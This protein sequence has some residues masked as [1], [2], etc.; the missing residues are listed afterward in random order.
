MVAKLAEVANYCVSQAGPGISVMAAVREFIAK[1]SSH[2]ATMSDPYYV[3]YTAPKN[4]DVVMTDL[5]KR[6]PAVSG[7]P[8]VLPSL[9]CYDATDIMI[10][11][12]GAL[13]IEAR[14]VRVISLQPLTFA[15]SYPVYLDHTMAEVWSGGK[16]S[17]Q[18]AFYNVEYLMGP[19]EYASVDDLCGAIN[20]S[21]IIPRNLLKTGWIDTGAE[22]LRIQDFFAGIEHRDDAGNSVV[23]MN[24]RRAD[25]NA[26]YSNNGTLTPM[27]DLI[28]G[29]VK[30]PRPTVIEIR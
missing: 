21:N 10:M 7:T 22:V 30:R 4:W 9:L 23:V 17:A 6:I 3:A 27:R 16:W 19:Y 20:L 14:S 2:P 15:G 28:I 18:D 24:Y 1:Y 26:L 5:W 11:I 8:Y 12:L 25:F 13:G 29:S